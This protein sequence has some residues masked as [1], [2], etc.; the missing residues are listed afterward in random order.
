V[1]QSLSRDAA[2]DDDVWSKDGQVV[3]LHSKPVP[4]IREDVMG[5]LWRQRRRRFFCYPSL[6]RSFF[7]TR[8]LGFIAPRRGRLN[9]NIRNNTFVIV[10]AVVLLLSSA[11]V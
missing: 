4:R 6:R 9:L 7:P 8:R 10:A 5:T 1:R 2:A 3:A 11:G